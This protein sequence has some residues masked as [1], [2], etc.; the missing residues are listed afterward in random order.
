MKRLT[1][2]A[3]ALMV[4]VSSFAAVS[5]ELSGGVTNDF[6]WTSPHDM[7]AGLNADVNAANN[8]VGEKSWGTLAE[9]RAL[10]DPVGGSIP[11]WYP[12]S[13]VP[14]RQAVLDV[15]QT[16]KWKWLFDYI[17]AKRAE[18]G[19]E[20]YG[21]TGTNM[22]FDLAAFFMNSQRTSWPKGPDFAAS[23]VDSYD[24]YKDTWKAAYANPTE[25]TDSFKLNPPYKEGETFD[26]W[27][28][29]AGE[30]VTHVDAT[31][32]GTLTARWMTERIPTIAEVLALADGTATAVAGT[33]TFVAGSQLWIQDATGAINLY[34]SDHGAKVADK[35]ILKGGKKTTYNGTPQVSEATEAIVE[36]GTAVIPV[37]T[38]LAD[39]NANLNSKLSHWVS[40]SGVRA[41][42]EGTD[43][44]LKENDLKV[45]VYKHSITKEELPEGQKL[46][47]NVLICQYQGN[48]QVRTN[49]ENITK[50]GLP[51][52]DDYAY[53]AR[54]EQGEY[55]LTNKWIFSDV[56]G[57]FQ[58]N[59][60]NG[61]ALYV[62]GMVEKGGIMY[63]VDREFHR[64]VPVDGETGIMLE[65]IPLPDNMWT[66]PGKA[67][68]GVTDSIVAAVVG[69]HDNDIKCDD[70]GHLLIG[71]Q[72]EK[73]TGTNLRDFQ[74]WKFDETTGEAVLVLHDEIDAN[75]GLDPW[76]IDAFDVY[77]D[78]D[79]DAV[80]MAC[81]AKA[82]NVFRWTIEGGKQKEGCEI[83]D[84]YV[85]PSENSKLIQDGA[86]IT[87]PGTAPQIYIV[88]DEYFYIDG[89]STYPT[90][91]DVTGTLADDFANC[92][93]GL[94][95]GNLDGD[96]TTVQTQQNGLIEFQVG[97]EYYLLITAAG[98]TGGNNFALYKYADEAR[99]WADMTPMWYFPKAGFGSQS[100][101]ARTAVPSVSVN[102]KTGL[103][104][105]Y[106]YAGENGYA[107]YEFQAVG[108]DGPTTAL[109]STTVEAPK[110]QKVLRDGQVI[111]IRN[112]VEYNVL[113]SQL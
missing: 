12:S 6:G 46:D 97:T 11:T 69:L 36:A 38:T 47:A 87:D 28:N 54:G 56:I 66:K 96:T 15:L 26:G 94:K 45:L 29:E 67:A 107:M 10:G 89:F 113:G 98:T 78:V 52:H 16:D 7:W 112:G 91:F 73:G 40:V 49:I 68:D 58:A 85:D 109:E 75:Y 14:A 59:K 53:P 22:V 103:A 3:T 79:G 99:S 48:L 5:Y 50:T 83:I 102:Q 35:I 17:D 62:R 33:V 90:L 37:S 44:Y 31:T 39:V 21:A 8:P 84:L 74:V 43:L 2:F 13:N 72:T 77:G 30:K 61:Q 80:I 20:A 4:A 23:G 100:A 55:R 81:N 82:M 105:L 19:L 42:W 106:L 18:G 65:Y 110:A 27:Y 32:T 64:L 111:I 95:V 1:L 86:M 34:H 76:R 24:A 60:P 92:P 25:P 63:F 70:A 101:G 9:A 51:A 108:E 104:K 93:F 71:C 41:T 88:G 57:N